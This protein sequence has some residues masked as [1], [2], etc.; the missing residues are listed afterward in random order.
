MYIV[1]KIVEHV[2]DKILCY[3][4]IKI[5]KYSRKCKMLVG[6]IIRIYDD[7]WSPERQVPT[8]I[9]NFLGSILVGLV[10]M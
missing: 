7:V 9:Q 10:S 2:V 8:V 4:K 5:V 3:I 6:F 1:V